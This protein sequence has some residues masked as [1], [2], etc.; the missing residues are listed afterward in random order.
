MGRIHKQ[1]AKIGLIIFT[2]LLAFQTNAVSVLAD[3][4]INS[5]S[6]LNNGLKIDAEGNISSVNDLTDPSKTKLDITAPANMSDQEFYDMMLKSPICWTPNSSVQVLTGTITNPLPQKKT[7]YKPKGTTFDLSKGTPSFRL[8][9]VSTTY[10]GKTVDLI[11]TVNNVHNPKTLSS[12]TAQQSAT[13]NNSINPA[14]HKAAT[15]LSSKAEKSTS[16]AKNNMTSSSDAT[17]TADSVLTDKEVTTS[18]KTKVNSESES[19]KVAEQKSQTQTKTTIATKEAEQN[20][21]EP[22]ITF[23]PDKDQSIKSNIKNIEGASISYQFV[24]HATG[25]PLN[26]MVFPAIN[27]IDAYQ[28]YEISNG[29][30]IGYD[31]NMLTPTNNG[32]FQANGTAVNGVQDFPNGGALFQYYGDQIQTT[33]LDPKGGSNTDWSA[34]GIFGVYGSLR[35]GTISRPNQSKAVRKIAFAKDGHLLKNKAQQTVNFKGTDTFKITGNDVKKTSSA[36]PDGTDNWN[37]I[38]VPQIA[39]YVPDTRKVQQKKVDSD[40]PDESKVITYYPKAELKVSDTNESKTSKNTLTKINEPF[41]YTTTQKV[42]ALEQD[43]DP[44]H[45]YQM[46]VKTDQPIDIKNVSVKN[47]L[48]K[49]VTNQFNVV[50]KNQN[51]ALL[52]AKNLADPSFYGQSYAVQL[53]ANL[54]NAKDKDVV[55]AYNEV[56][57]N[58]T[59]YETAQVTTLVKAEQR[60][61][62]PAKQEPK[63]PNHRA[64]S[65][66]KQ[67]KVAKKQS[68]KKHQAKQKA[69]QKQHKQTTLSHLTKAKK[70]QSKTIPQATRKSVHHRKTV[71]Q[72]VGRKKPANH[73]VKHVLKQQH[74]KRAAKATYKKYP[75]PKL[76]SNV[77]QQ[78]TGISRKDQKALFGALSKIEKYGKKHGWS[79]ARIQRAQLT[80]MTP[81]YLDDKK[82]ILVSGP[83]EKDRKINKKILGNAT[84]RH[85]YTIVGK[86]DNGQGTD[87]NLKKKQRPDLQHQM[88]IWKSYQH[89]RP[90]MRALGSTKL[91]MPWNYPGPIGGILFSKDLYDALKH[92][93]KNMLAINSLVG[94]AYQRFGPG[95]FESDA[96]VLK[97][98]HKKYGNRPVQDMLIDLYGQKRITNK[99]RHKFLNK[100]VSRKWLEKQ[101]NKTGTIIIAAITALGFI[102]GKDF[103]LKEYR[104]QVKKN[105]AWY[106]PSGSKKPKQPP[107]PKKKKTFK[108]RVR[109]AQNR[110]D[111]AKKSVKQRY[112]KTVRGMNQAG[113]KFKRG[114]DQTARK[115]VRSAKQNFDKAKKSVKHTYRKTVRGM[116]QAGYKFKR[117]VDQTARKFVRSAKQTYRSAKRRVKHTYQKAKKAVK[118]TYRRAKR[119]V[120]HTYQ[121]AKKAVKSTYRRVKRRVKHTYRKAKKAVKKTYRRVKRRVKHTYRKAKK[122]VKKTYRRVKRRIKHTYR[123]AKKA[124]KKTYRRFKRGLKHNY[125]KMKKRIR[126]TVKRYSKKWHKFKK[127]L[128]R[129]RKAKKRR[130]KKRKG[131]SFMSRFRSWLKNRKRNRRRKKHLKKAR[132][133]RKKRHK[134]RNRRRRRKH[135]T[136]RKRR[137]KR[138]RRGRKRRRKHRR[139]GRKRRRKHRRRGRKRRRKRRRRGRK[140]R[141]KRRRRGR[142]R[143]RKRRRRGQKRRRKRRRRGRKR[144][145]KRRRRGRKRRRKRRRRGRKRRRKRRRR[146][147]KRRRKRRRRGRKRRRK[148]RRGRKRRRR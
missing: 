72:A 99:D 117:G 114:V 89:G 64:S 46:Q 116:N 34:S 55:K 76:K 144:R 12:K 88:I 5:H 113:H 115:F 30:A 112:R 21:D 74:K 59:Q 2:I 57:L 3:M 47:E 45:K 120:K 26:I 87:K 118:N 16:S 79:A 78:N 6:T 126:R 86:R 133:R 15:T 83:T 56:T 82:Q 69:P 107:K 148:R 42:P 81:D 49:D 134:K 68:V 52:V 38:S 96:D 91:R 1:C 44:L 101:K 102:K 9:N 90:V 67:A 7:G 4:H 128:K 19:S 11:I 50:N 145:R 39:G 146:G 13:I 119:R 141:R 51:G 54:K 138:R 124:V 25:K 104:K 103:L 80:L 17:S 28:V 24:D 23:S 58:D 66:K 136:S 94:D 85:V 93:K 111:K 132:R 123:R 37:S 131:K 29:K 36:K 10:S 41:I 20:S 40:T 14:T 125:R 139:R 105:K 73:T 106:Y 63:K 31:T 75:K 95:D 32:G 130:R 97:M 70:R 33:F 22:Q 137:K 53:T 109:E 108:Q 18:N 62:P 143:R 100:H 65:V 8:T 27:D 110:F 61:M 60:A 35:N 98:V 43:A 84:I 140:R 122:V 121:K 142:K 147:R 135:R 92:N 127:R 48:G 129:K 71:S 77:F